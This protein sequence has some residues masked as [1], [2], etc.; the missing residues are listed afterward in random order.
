[1]FMELHREEKREEGDR[2]GREDKGVESKGERQIQLIISSLSVLHYPEH[3]KRFTEL[4]KKEMATHSSV[5]AWRIPRMEEP[6]GPQFMG[7]QR[8]GHD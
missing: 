6:G 8:V 4:G 1:M 3:T 7:S 2:D 5:L